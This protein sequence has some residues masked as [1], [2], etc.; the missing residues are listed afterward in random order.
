MLFEKNDSSVMKSF[1]K[2]FFYSSNAND[3]FRFGTYETV[4]SDNKNA[5][6]R[7][8]LGYPNGHRAQV[9]IT[10]AN[11]RGTWKLAYVESGL[12]F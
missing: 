2:R 5:I 6:V 1:W 9:D 11:E 4:Q 10:M 7:I 12:P 3:F 8:H